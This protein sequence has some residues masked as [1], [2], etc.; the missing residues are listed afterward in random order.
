[1]RLL[2]ERF[3]V[4]RSWATMIMITTATSLITIMT[5]LEMCE[6]QS[7]NLFGLRAGV[8]VL[9]CWCETY[10]CQSI[11]G[12]RLKAANESNQFTG[13]HFARKNKTKRRRNGIPPTGISRKPE[14][15]G[16]LG[17]VHQVNVIQ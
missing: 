3:R 14:E 1:M 5:L 6:D 11:A 9:G 8:Q 10:I 13:S 12:Q 7:S 4:C 15:L 17:R 16:E 2:G